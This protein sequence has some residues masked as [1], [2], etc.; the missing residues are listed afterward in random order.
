V[1]NRHIAAQK[2][3]RQRDRNHDGKRDRPHRA[4]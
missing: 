1:Q 3:D 4:N 2:H